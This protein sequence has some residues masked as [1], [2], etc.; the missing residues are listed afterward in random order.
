M[1]LIIRNKKT[2]DDT[3]I[4]LLK[5]AKKVKKI[6]KKGD[7]TIIYDEDDIVGINLINSSKYFPFRSGART[8]NQ[9]EI[10][11][12]TSHCQ[13][14]RITPF[15]KIGEI[16]KR[17]AHP[18]SAKLFVLKIK[19]DEL[20]TIVTNTTNSIV[21]TKVVVAQINSILPSGVIITKSKIM[22]I[23]SAGM[24]CGAATFNFP[25]QPGALLVKGEN[26]KEFIL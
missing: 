15:F 1:S 4:I 22:G 18:E 20:I 2:L 6:R 26:G 7:F 19:T 12:L 9:V 8:L 5:G 23:E 25:S 10:D 16:I 13:N 3:A 11:T 24:L 21:G 14:L 17:E